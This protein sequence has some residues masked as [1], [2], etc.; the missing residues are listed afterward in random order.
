[1]SKNSNKSNGTHIERR[2]F[3]R[4]IAGGL[5]AGSAA[6]T[7]PLTGSQQRPDQATKKSSPGGTKVMIHPLAVPRK[8]D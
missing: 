8:K 1:M 5:A 6:L 4:K 7:I 2:S 3:L